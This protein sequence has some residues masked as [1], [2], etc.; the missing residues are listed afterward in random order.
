MKRLGE[1]L[2]EGA[3]M[4]L[5][6]PVLMKHAKTPYGFGRVERDDRDDGAGPVTACDTNRPCGDRVCFHV[7][8]EPGASTVRVRFEGEGCALAIGAASA[9]CEAV[10]GR[11]LVEARRIV[12]GFAL[13]LTDPAHDER[14]TGDL[15]H[16]ARA[17]AFPARVACVTLGS[18]VLSHALDRLTPEGGPDDRRYP[19]R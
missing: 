3:E 19:D 8:A 15:A 13:A 10:D 18:A 5:Y 1:E 14:V 9:L 7:V 11:E 2:A 4:S 16:F 17:R 12:S 6:D